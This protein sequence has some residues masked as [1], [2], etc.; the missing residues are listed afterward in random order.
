MCTFFR[1]EGNFCRFPDDEVDIPELVGEEADVRQL[2]GLHQ[3]ETVPHHRYHVKVIETGVT[4]MPVDGV[5]RLHFV[6][7][8]SP[9]N[10]VEVGPN[11]RE[12]GNRVG[13]ISSR[14]CP[15]KV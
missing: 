12:K 3:V 14:M 15:R 13:I 8:L 9:V 1:K 5:N 11:M 10:T 2:S 6:F 7:G 4:L